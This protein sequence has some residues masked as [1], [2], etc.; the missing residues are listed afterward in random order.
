MTCTKKLSSGQLKIYA[1]GIF[2]NL[3]PD[4]DFADLRYTGTLPR[5]AIVFLVCAILFLNTDW[6][7][8]VWISVGVL[9]VYWLAMTLVP[10]PGYGKV[11]LEP[12]RNL[13]AWLDTKW[14]PG[15]MWQGTWDPEGILSTFPSIVT[16]IT[17]ILAGHV[18]LSKHTRE[19]KVI[20][21]MVAGFFAAGA[22]YV[23]GLAFPV[24]ENIWTSSF[25]LVTSGFGAMMLGA[26]YFIV[27]MLGRK[28]GTR[29]GIIF[30]ANAITVYVLADIFALLFYEIK[31]G[32]NTLNGYF[33]DAFTSI[34]LGPKLVSMI[35]ALIF[36]CINYIPAYIL[37]KKK[38]FIKL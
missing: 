36:V 38:I 10:T 8:Q 22:G 26:V 2:L 18:I 6:K 23:W 9:V 32:G 31:I 12:G 29:P 11:M 7:K 14:L 1:V 28:K 4:F 21:L 13:A 5:I 35:Y 37:Y 27:D 34:G 30:G 20:Y 24:N 17:G 33:F 15:T 3:L 19:Q 25:V 16:G